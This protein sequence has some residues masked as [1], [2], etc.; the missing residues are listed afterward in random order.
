M[1]VVGPTNGAAWSG[2][3]HDVEL[4]SWVEIQPTA[5]QYA[6]TQ[7]P[8]RHP[9]GLQPA[10]VVQSLL[11]KWLT[12]LKSKAVIS[13][14]ED[15]ANKASRQGSDQAT[16]SALGSSTEQEE[17]SPGP[18]RAPRVGVSGAGVKELVLCCSVQK[19]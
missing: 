12:E 18:A 15:A 1:V 16:G 5:S 10:L 3:Q 4:N 6:S 2:L 17:H 13:D 7:R 14:G 8:P 11:S 19:Q 9:R